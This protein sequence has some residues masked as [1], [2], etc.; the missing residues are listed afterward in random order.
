[1]DMARRLW[2]AQEVTWDTDG[3]QGHVFLTLD[4]EVEVGESSASMH[5]KNKLEMNG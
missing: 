3:A 4:D 5:N 1:M 2:D